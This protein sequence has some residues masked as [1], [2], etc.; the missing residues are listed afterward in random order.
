VILAGLVAGARLDRQGD[1]RIGANVLHLAVLEQVARHQF[2]ALETDP[3]DRNLGP[4][5]RLERDQVGQTWA[6]KHRPG[7]VGN[8][9]VPDATSEATARRDGRLTCVGPPLAERGQ[10]SA[11]PRRPAQI[12][13]ESP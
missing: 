12:T 1:T 8:D 13:K 4:P 2:I 9:H 7:G 6:L 5:V 3:H 10:I 11:T